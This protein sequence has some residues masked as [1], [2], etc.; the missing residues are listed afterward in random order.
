MPVFNSEDKPASKPLSVSSCLYVLRVNRPEVPPFTPDAARQILTGHSDFEIHKRHHHLPIYTNLSPFLG[1]HRLQKFTSEGDRRPCE[2]I[3][4]SELT[5]TFHCRNIP[6]HLYKCG[7]S[8]Y[9][10]LNGMRMERRY[11]F[12]A[13]FSLLGLRIH[14]LR[15]FPVDR[16][17]THCQPPLQP[18]P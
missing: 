3:Q 7:G 1:S 6:P 8:Q 18:S 14:V 4:S 12:S 15:T 10:I 11:R 5:N 17:G 16:Q 2:N 13:L 9:S